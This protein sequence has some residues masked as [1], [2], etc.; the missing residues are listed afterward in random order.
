V[1]RPIKFEHYR[2]VGDRRTQTVY[3]I[4]ELEDESVIADLLGG[5]RTEGIN[6]VP[7]TCFAPD[8]LVEARNR[9]YKPYRGNGSGRPDTDGDD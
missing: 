5:G 2:Y 6:G 1:K 3:D 8:T 4:D 9:G 7:Y